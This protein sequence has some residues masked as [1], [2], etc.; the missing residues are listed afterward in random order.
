[1]HDKPK[2]GSQIAEIAGQIV[3]LLDPLASKDR[4]RVINGALTMLGETS[5]L[6]ATGPETLGPA[7]REASE[8]I[9]TSQETDGL[10]AKSKTWIKQNGITI[11]QLEQLFD[12][13]SDGVPV[14]APEV[15]GKSD[16]EQT[17]N[18]YILNGVS[19]FLASGDTSFDDKAARKLCE[20]LGCYNSGNHATYMSNKGNLLTGSKAVGWKLTAPGLKHG[21]NL[22]K[23]LAR[24]A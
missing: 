16:K 10:S 8:P 20:N 17:L 7:S 1:M 22:I 15:P 14:I 12:I 24:E 4:Q 13:S 19:R 9:K 21:A 11:A 6:G 23:Q 5:T 2:A 3:R 18:A